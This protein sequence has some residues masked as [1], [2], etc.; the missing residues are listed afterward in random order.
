MH[1]LKCHFKLHGI[2]IG[3][4]SETGPSSPDASS[5]ELAL[6]LLAMLVRVTLALESP[7]ASPTRRLFQVLTTVIS[8]WLSPTLANGAMSMR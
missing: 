5:G 7:R 2:V 8:S 1:R 3:N 6:N 4:F